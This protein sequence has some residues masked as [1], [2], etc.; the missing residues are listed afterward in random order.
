MVH[1]ANSKA[2][3]ARRRLIG[4]LRGSEVPKAASLAAVLNACTD[5]HP[6]RSAACPV[7]GTALQQVAVSVVDQFIRVPARAIRSRMHALTIVPASGCLAPDDLTVEACE[8]VG[9]EIAAAFARLGLLPCIIGLEV[10]FNEDQT[11]EVEP[12]W[13][14]H[15]HANGLD[16][17]SSTQV[18]DLRAAFPPSELVK[19]PIRC[20]PLDQDIRGRLY[21]FKPERLR[22]VTS[23]VEDD[24]ERK[25]Y[26]ETKRRPLR[27]WQAVSLAIV[28]HQLGFQGRLLLHGIDE[29][30]VRR[31]LAGLGWARDGPSEHQ[32]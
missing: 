7:C 13:C 26:R 18:K 28:D 1:D 23:L 11:G 4:Q 21:P 6:C 10:S 27:P 25:P 15:G 14:V 2:T 19:R 12:H 30:A 9:A 24:P 16:W 5:M 29:E 17:L 31:H 8:R 3:H 22:R 20:E 32:D